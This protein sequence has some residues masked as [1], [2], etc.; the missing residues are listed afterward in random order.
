MVNTVSNYPNDP[1]ELVPGSTLNVP[2][3]GVI[4]TKIGEYVPPSVSANYLGLMQSLYQNLLDAST[5][6]DEI[7]NEIIDTLQEFQLFGQNGVPDSIVPSI[8]QF[9]TPEMG[10]YLSAVISTLSSAGITTPPPAN[11]SSAAKISLVQDWQ[12]L[13][14]F[15]V[16]LLIQQAL[17]VNTN[18]QSLQSMV[19][20][21][22][23]KVGNDQLFSQLQSM[24]QALSTTQLIINQLT[25]IENISNMIGLSPQGNF[26]FPPTNNSQIPSS[27]WD[28]SNPMSTP[29]FRNEANIYFQQSASEDSIIPDFNAGTVGGHDPQN[30]SGPNWISRAFAVD[31]ITSGGS[32]TSVKQSGGEIDFESGESG[33]YNNDGILLKITLTYPPL[34][35]TAA[36]AGS[37]LAICNSQASA[38]ALFATTFA[39]KNILANT[40]TALSQD[41]GSTPIT[42]SQDQNGGLNYFERLYKTMASAQFSQVFPFVTAN[43]STTPAQLLAAKSALMNAINALTSQNPTSQGVT[44]INSLA[45]LCNQVTADISAAFANTST[46]ASAVTKWILDGQDKRISGS[47]T[48][49]AG[50]IQQNITSA[51]Q[52]AQSL[53]SVQQQ[54]VQNYMFMFQQFYQSASSVLQTVSQMITSTAQN[55]NR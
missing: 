2:G 54:N 29:L 6:K 47:Q 21:Q 5:P 41:G 15:G 7:Y 3:F 22:Y 40:I 12:A 24:Q 42:G 39:S 13:A 25:I 34:Y 26:T 16:Q 14:G 8:K 20:L 27:L 55:I 4:H 36:A 37:P 32:Y 43:L 30:A 10:Q 17:G 45:Y 51:T 18:A 53:N 35:G 50:A 9:M 28:I 38:N 48:G 49:N 23:V 44:V 46:Q 31:W 11:I 1:S 19:E 52:S 33:G